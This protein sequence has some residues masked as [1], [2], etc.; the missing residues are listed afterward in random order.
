MKKTLL[1]LIFM[2]FTASLAFGAALSEG[3]E[4]WPPTDWTIVQGPC[5]PTNDITQNGDQFYS[6][7]YSAR[8]PSYDECLGGYDEYL[9]TP[10][11]ITTSGDQTISFWYIKY[12]YGSEVFKV[13]WSST[14]TDVSTD[15]TWS[16]E[17]SDAST[18]WQQYSKTD[19]PI[20]TKYVAF[21]Y[22]SNYA[23]YLYIDDVAGPAYIVPSCPDPASL[24]ATNVGQTTADLG[25]TET[26]SATTWEYAIGVAPFAEPT[27]AGTSTTDNPVSIVG[28][29]VGTTYDWY[30]RAD[31]GSKDVSGW[32][33]STF[34]TSSPGNDCSDPIIV[35]F[36][37]DLPYSDSGQTTC[38]R[39]DDYMDTG[40]GYYDSG[41]DIIYELTVGTAGNYNFTMTTTTTYTGMGI[42][43]T[44]P[45]G[46]TTLFLDTNSSAGGCEILLADLAVGTYYL[47]IDTWSLPDC[48]PTFDLS[49]IQVTCP[50][51]TTLTV[52]NISQTTADLGWTE[53]GSATTWEYAYGVAPFAEPTG[54]GTSTT[55]NP[56]SIAGLS[57]NTT[58][59]WYVRADCGSGSKDLSGW[60]GPATFTTLCD[61][62]TTYP[63]LEEFT[64]WPPA[65]FDLTGGTGSWDHYVTTPC[66][67][68]N[69]WS[70]STGTTVY[71]TT[72][73]FDVST[74]TTPI[75]TFDWSHLYNPTYP[76][77]DLE[78]LV[79]DD[80]GTIWTQVW[81]KG[82]TDLNSN[83]GAGST[84]P[85][86]FVSSGP[87]DLSSFGTDLIIRFLGTSG[88][89]PDL[90]V[91]NVTVKEMPIY[92]DLTMLAPVGSG[93][94]VPAVGVHTY[95]ENTVVNLVGQPQLAVFDRWEVDGSLHTTDRV[96]TL[97][98]DTAHNAQS[99]HSLSAGALA[100]DFSAGIAVPGEWTETNTTTAW[101]LG[102]DTF[103]FTM[104][105]EYSLI[106]TD[107]NVTAEMLITPLL[108]LDGSITELNYWLAGGNSTAGFGGSTVQVKY[109]PEAADVW[110]DIGSAIDLTLNENLRYVTVDLSALPNG[111]Y[112]FA[113]NV[114]STFNYA[115]YLSW[116]G[117]DNVVGP[118]M[119]SVQDD[120]L[121]IVSVDYE[122]S[123]IY[124]GNI[125]Q[126]SVEVKNVG[127]NP[128][129]GT[130]VTVD[131]A[132]G[133]KTTLTTNI[134]TLAYS[135]SEIVTVNY[136]TV[137]GRHLITASV[138]R[139]DNPANDSATT[140][141]VVATTGALAEGFES[142]YDTWSVAAE[143]IQWNQ[144]WL[145]PYEGLYSI[146]AG[147]GASFTDAY[148]VSPKVTIG[149]ADE[150]NF[151][152]SY[153]NQATGL[154]DLD[155]AHPSDGV[156][157]TDLIAGIIPLDIMQLYT[158]DLSSVT[159]GDYYL[160]F[161][162]SGSGD[163]TYSTWI[164]VDHV[165]GPQLAPP[166]APENVMIQVNSGT[167]EVVVSWDYIAGLVYTV[168]S[169]VDPYGAF[170]T[171]VQSGIAAGSWT[172]SPISV[173]DEFYQVT[174][175]YAP[176]V[177]ARGD[178]AKVQTEPAAEA[179]LKQNTVI[180][181]E[182]DID[183]KTL[184]LEQ[185]STRN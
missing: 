155:A 134:G 42:F 6:G 32:A 127:L 78:V 12:T 95:E 150:L 60:A 145:P 22:Y 36:S 82:S 52:A 151:Y 120:D 114:I 10:E 40:L 109:Q 14:G 83:D 1:I 156:T 63:W 171:E 67:R 7:V 179:Q 173:V 91:D 115:G 110:S 149:A 140:Q 117:I 23:Y 25:W 111:N 178:N 72:P 131:I 174:A 148:L 45:P 94:P 8:F 4:T 126:I 43:D 97:T 28:L 11:L 84:A 170:G 87:I 166:D 61:P 99:F 27:G 137:G 157:W 121:E 16:T 75:L 73:E 33:G 180:Q 3:F 90:F 26:G 56:V 168:D 38:G 48:I 132:D 105:D 103:F 108:T 92:H 39:V 96:S 135:E 167:D 55:D 104:F 124:A 89:G 88:W 130:L 31:C 169:D 62:V 85:G 142:T 64:T 46:A 37:S 18:T 5:S 98:M 177:A 24:T 79:T 47:M 71:M 41:E 123:I 80:G 141:C 128:Q 76:L 74:L 106:G 9:V 154:A 20:G 49:I 175:D 147:T 44:C 118:V 100:E 158:V 125:G 35:D 153:G 53:T 122:H 172:I 15:F 176:P 70:L 165:V 159:P 86:T 146:A 144:T 57:A 164:N 58:Y 129:S 69:Y 161:R 160:A 21:H 30:V 133:S 102:D 113:F 163:G 101:E 184:K 138:P 136:T 139:D 68:A 17:I 143:W 152:A 81:Y 112:N 93:I 107:I 119:A 54:A 183:V 2:L 50:E 29:T 34:T 19:L 51:P 182:R 77:D 13:G 59:D 66:A 116:V 162:A 65:C 181:T 185:K